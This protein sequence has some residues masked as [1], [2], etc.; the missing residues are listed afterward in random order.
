MTAHPC[1]RWCIVL[2]MALAA[3]AS[4]HA[5]T[6]AKGSVPPP[7]PSPLVE[8]PD[9]ALYPRTLSEIK[10]M[11]AALTP[12]R[13]HWEHVQ[14]SFLTRLKAQRYICGIPYENLKWSNQLEE[15]VRLGVEAF[16]MNNEASH[17]PKKPAQMS[18]EDFKK[19]QHGAGG[20]IFAG[21]TDPVACVDGW[22]YDSAFGEFNAVGHRRWCIHPGMIEAA[23]ATKGP[24]ALMQFNCSG[25]ARDWDYVAFPA[26]GYMPM[27]LN[28][29]GA[30]TAWSCSLNMGK[31][32][33]PQKDLVK[34]TVQPLNEKLEGLG[35]PYPLDCLTV[36]CQGFGSGPAIVFRPVG[37]F[38][39]DGFKMKHDARCR[40]TITG[41]QDKSNKPAQIQYVVHFVDL[42]KVSDSPESRRIVSDHLRKRL[43]AIQAGSDKVEKWE[44][45]TAFSSGEMLTSA[46]PSLAK[47]AQ[48][49]IA[50][51]LKDPVVRKEYEAALKHDA[52]TE[53]EQKAGK[54][55]NK[56]RKREELIAVAAAYRDVATFSKGT[57]AGKKSAADFERLSK[58]L[59]L[60]TP[61]VAAAT[62]EP[63]APA[64]AAATAPPSRSTAPQPVLAPAKAT[65][66]PAVLDQWQA[67]LVKKLDALARNGTKLRLHKAGQENGEIRGANDTTLTVRIQGNDLP[68]PWKQLS[69]ADRAALAK[70]TVKDDDVEALLIAAVFQLADGNAG[71]AE[72]LF[73][74]A[75][76]KDAGAVKDAKATLASP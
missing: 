23:F 64:P 8:Q 54:Q 35:E 49:G 38:T 4:V 50:Q 5:A 68:M 34:V 42:K 24:F 43:D 31:Y 62:P 45:L 29:M 15:C 63:A 14:E 17:G 73:G 25:P 21:L 3:G 52:V 58:D 55:K 72:D 18:D 9:P 26:R 61:S 32:Q 37:G 2:A 10:G 12:P 28:Y 48:E 59:G 20:N 41:L 69:L 75:A 19:A 67:R 53:M 70:E 74:K 40:V 30:A 13:N 22:M 57:R 76:V 11:L 7:A 1:R 46:D 47:E 66:A 65:V 16:C 39:S 60:S 27:E 6:P 33:C 44:A 71:T 51:L 36:E 56:N